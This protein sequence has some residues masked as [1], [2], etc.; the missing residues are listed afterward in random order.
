LPGEERAVALARE[1]PGSSVIGSATAGEIAAEEF[2]AALMAFLTVARRTRGRLQPLFVDISVPQLV[3]LDAVQ[4]C[5]D[6]GIHAVS[7][8]ASLSQ[9]S[10]TQQ[11]AALELKGLLRRV[12]ASEDRRRRVLVLTQEGQECLATKRAVVSE[13]F[14]ATWRSLDPAERELAAPLLRHLAELVEH[15]A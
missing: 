14:Q 2:A 10:V 6:K 11:A 15:L 12:P 4:A 9:P 13:R 7:E 8:Y 5:G 3:V 1:G